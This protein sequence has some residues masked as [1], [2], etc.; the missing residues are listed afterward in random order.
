MM[1]YGD[2]WCDGGGVG[3]DAIWGMTGDNGCGGII[4]GVI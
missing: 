3:Y 2:I 4:D 1:G